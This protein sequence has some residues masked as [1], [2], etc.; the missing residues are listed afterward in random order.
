M[1]YKVTVFAVAVAV[2]K[3]VIYGCEFKNTEGTESGVYNYVE[4]N[5]LG[6]GCRKLFFSTSTQ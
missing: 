5:I 1:T 3:Q 4:L 6:V 2:F